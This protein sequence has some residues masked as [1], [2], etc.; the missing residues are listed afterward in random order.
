MKLSGLPKSNINKQSH[1][2]IK[3]YAAGCAWNSVP[4]IIPAKTV[5]KRRAKNRMARHSRQKNR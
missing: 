5:N 2:V 4:G 1:V 3:Q